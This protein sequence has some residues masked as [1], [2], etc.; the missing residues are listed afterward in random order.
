LS[1][2]LVIAFLA[3]LITQVLGLRE[4]NNWLRAATGAAS[5]LSVLSLAL[6][7]ALIADKRCWSHKG[8]G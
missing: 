4:S 6:K 8:G 5:S 3:D 1:V 2:F 7:G